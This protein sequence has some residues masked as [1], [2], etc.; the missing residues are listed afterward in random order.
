MRWRLKDGK[1]NE[2]QAFFDTAH[3]LMVQQGI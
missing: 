2:H 3:L 1:I